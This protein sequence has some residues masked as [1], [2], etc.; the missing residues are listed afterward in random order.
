MLVLENGVTVS[1]DLSPNPTAFRV[2]DYW[3]FTARAADGSVEII[4]EAPPLG[5][6][7]HYAKLGIVTFPSIITPC[8]LEWPPSAT[9]SS[10]CCSITVTPNGLTGESTLQSV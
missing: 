7:H 10:C 4:T 8:R 5:I 3:L 9:G 2:A 1:F 6:N